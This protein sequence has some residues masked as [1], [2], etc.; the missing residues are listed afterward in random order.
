MPLHNGSDRDGSEVVQVYLHDPVAE[1][2]RPVQRLIGAARVD[3]PAGGSCTAVL[4]LHADL[5]SYTGLGGER[6]VEPGEVELWVGAS[7]TD[8][9]SRLRLSMT[10]PRRSVGYDRVMQPE[11]TIL[12]RDIT[13]H[14]RQGRDPIVVDN[15][16][17][18]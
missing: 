16:F 15:G 18:G 2:V 10:G 7:S 12:N 4:D 9:R 5:A 6:I 1:V 3:L 14:Q 17:R 8:I 11:I 13:P